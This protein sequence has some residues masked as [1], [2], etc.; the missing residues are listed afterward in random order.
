MSSGIALSALA[1]SGNHDRL[2]KTETT[3]TVGSGGSGGTVP[4]VG[5]GKVGGFGGSGP[6]E[7]PGPTKLTLVNGIVDDAAAR[8]CFVPHPGG[9]T[10]EQ[11]W[12]GIEGLAFAKGSAI[13]LA[14][15]I[16]S[17]G[18]VEIHVFAGILSGT[19]KS[20]AELI[21]AP[22]M[23][24]RHQSLGIVPASAFDEE[25]SLLMVAAG[26]LG[27]KGYTDELETLVCG[28][29]YTEDTPTAYLSAGF[30]SRLGGPNAVPLQFVHSSLGMGDDVAAYFQQGTASA[31][32]LAMVSDWSF[33]S[34]GPFPPYSALSSSD[35]GAPSLAAVQIYSSAG[36]TTP[37]YE[38]TLEQIFANSSLSESELADG[39]G[40]SFIAVGASPAASSGPWWNPITITVVKSDP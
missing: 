7:P 40:L 32:T 23:F 14:A 18:D 39:V 38:S 29:Q 17:R 26:C 16:P 12:P 22:P 33:G 27:G 1:C 24:V 19:D 36:G 3:V 11:P 6:I 9:A 31:P 28:L 30:M 5:G 34:I 10:N 13:D 35:I 37:I 2:A 21:S 4:T 15:L 8:F 25:K 20:C